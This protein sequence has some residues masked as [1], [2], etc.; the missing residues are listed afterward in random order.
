MSMERRGDARTR[1]KNLLQVG[2]VFV[3]LTVVAIFFILDLGDEGGEPVMEKVMV[4]GINYDLP[5]P[6]DDYSSRSKLESVQRE[7]SRLHAEKSQRRAQSASFDML[8]SLR[9]SKT[10]V[11]DPIEVENLLAKI[12]DEPLT[13]MQPEEEMREEKPIVRKKR[14]ASVSTLSCVDERTVSIDEE[15]ESIKREDAQRRIDFGVGTRKDSILLGL[16]SPPNKEVKKPV[17]EK[18]PVVRQRRFPTEEIT[19]D[20]RSAGEIRAVIHGDQHKV[21]SS[22]QVKI[23]L[24]EPVKIGNVTIPESTIVD[25][26]VTFLDNRVDITI[27]GIRYKDAI[28]PFNGVVYDNN[29]QRGLFT[30]RDLVNETV[31]DAASDSYAKSTSGNVWGVMSNVVNKVSGR[32]DDL[33]RKASRDDHVDLPANYKIFIRRE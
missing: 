13:Q 3:F 17:E 12:E 22:S 2:G 18:T 33:R 29:A 24:C 32:V 27:K 7:Q 5:D 16:Y 4:S 6:N 31:R 8:N 15:I 11:A 23:R 1:R 9:P 20:E 19:T 28:Y 30:G 10:E 14:A 21:R 25:G 26:F